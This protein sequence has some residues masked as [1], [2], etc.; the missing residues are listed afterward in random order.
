VDI[1]VAVI[2]IL[3]AVV[4]GF[5]VHRASLCNVRAV[6]ELLTTRRAYMLGSFFKTMLWVIAVTFVIR[7]F[8]QPDPA[9][10]LHLWGFSLHALTG[11]FVF[12]VGAAVN[13]GCALGTIGRLGSGELR[14]FLTLLG[15]V[16]GLTGG[17]YAQ[18][19]QWL[20][21]PAG[22]GPAV[23]MPAVLAVV[24]ATFLSLWALWEL[25]RLWRKR[26]P[27][28]TL[29]EAVLSPRYR[30]ST[31]AL[32][33]G[34]ANGILFA[35]FG[36]WTYTRTARAAVNHVVMGRPGPGLLYW[37]L[38]A[39]VL[40]GVVLSSLANKS[41]VFD[42]RIRLNWLLN[43]LG[44][45]LM[46]VGATLIPGGNDALI[47]HAIPG[48]SPHALPAYA[49]LLAGTAAGLIVIRAIAGTA[50]KVECTGDIC[51]TRSPSRR[52]GVSAPARS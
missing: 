23:A 20:P 32:L 3:L 47:L 35:L 39:A 51:R 16:A 22:G 19:R 45:I 21:A 15:L 6:A 27:T 42:G 25:W 9:R 46:G 4:I 13:G 2:A 11:G 30:L 8:A 14:M 37:L 40:A 41:F 31:A 28:S 49:S 18:V 50:V 17:G 44:G 48:G 1:V 52:T 24:G 43:F 34:V 5:A 29:R 36:A 38:F 7:F 10:P 26:D 33:L 12:G